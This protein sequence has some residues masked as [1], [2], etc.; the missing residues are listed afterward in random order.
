MKKI[1]LLLCTAIFTNQFIIAQVA[2]NTDGTTPNSSAMLDIKS[3]TKGLL[4]PR[5]T[6]AQ[7]N[8][9]VSPATG[10]MVFDTDVNK[11]FFYASG[12]WIEIGTGSATNYW[13]LNGNNIYNNNAGN[14]G[15]GT[16]NPLVPLH[17]NKTTDEL[18]RLQGLNPYLSFYNNGAVKSYVQAYGDDLL[19]GTILGNTN[20][21]IRF[22]NNNIN[23]MTI[24]SNGNVG[25]GTTAPT[26]PLSFPNLLGNK[27]S[28]WNA[29]ATHDFGIG[30]ASGAMRLYT[31]G[32]DRISFGWGDA[33]SFIESATLFT[34]NGFLGLNTTNPQTQLHINKNDE[35]LRLSGTNQYLSFYDGSSYKGYMWNNSGSIEMGTDGTNT[36]GEVRLR[37]K[38]QQGLTVQSD[39]RVRVGTVSSNIVYGVLGKA[40]FTVT[41]V[42]GF[43]STSGDQIGEWSIFYHTGAPNTDDLEF[44]YNGGE[45]AKVS[46]VDG[47]WVSVSDFRLKESFENYNPVLERIKKLDVLSYRYKADKHKKFRIDS[48]KCTAVFSRNRFYKWVWRI[49][50]H[51]LRQNRRTRYKS[52]TG[53]TSDN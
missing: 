38:G 51:C 41:N 40:N 24:L 31:A 45:K 32:Q 22:Y 12:S 46:D 27:I 14:V 23:N 10:L 19:L 7:R 15:I 17:I 21:A 16:S 34:G 4:A 28:L 9:I 42:L 3:T 13:T 18:L 50:G 52:N 1:L 5:M 20:G 33:S 8:A 29:D 53:T 37:T 49:N 26:A 11:F 35:A 47:D 2:I 48:A 36:N 6:T 25:I 30:I 39:G 44:Y 43:K